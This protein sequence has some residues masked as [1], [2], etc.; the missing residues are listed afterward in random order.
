[1]AA[2]DRDSRVLETTITART[3]PITFALHA[4][5]PNPFNLETQI[6]FDLSEACHV[7][8]KIYN[9]RGQ[10]VRA[11]L[12]ASLPAGRYTVQWDGTNESGTI[13]ASGVYFC[14]MATRNF[15]S[16]KKMVMMK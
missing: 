14:S 15:F 6:R 16:T 11:L 13:V 1:M 5:Y 12:D 9:I 10:L 7:S 2:V 8:L 4:A 3:T